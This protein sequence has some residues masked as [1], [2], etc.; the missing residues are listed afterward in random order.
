MIVFFVDDIVKAAE[1]FQIFVMG[2]SSGCSLNVNSDT[3]YVS[4]QIPRLVVPVSLIKKIYGAYLE[5]C[6]P[7]GNSSSSSMTTCLSVEF[8][9]FS[10]IKA[11]LVDKGFSFAEISEHLI[12]VLGPENIRITVVAS[13][14]KESAQLLPRLMSL[15]NLNLI[16][17][18][19]NVTNEVINRKEVNVGEPIPTL[20]LS[21]LNSSNNFK[22]FKPIS[23]NMQRP[24][25]FKTELFDGEILFLVNTANSSYNPM[26]SQSCTS[27]YSAR[28]TGDSHKI[29][30]DLQVQ[31][32]FLQIPSG[33]LFC[34]AEISKCMQLSLIIRGMCG[35]I[36][37]L[38]R[39]MNAS[40]HHSFGD[41]DNFEKP[42][43]VSPL[44]YVEAVVS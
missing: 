7:P 4:I 36:L 19:S 34:G 13:D 12:L 22:L 15:L 43:I 44:W 8:A 3:D 11:A 17:E 6:I 40:L 24:I 42:H 16:K 20:H 9:D 41:K 33:K 5:N 2:I 37:Q 28:F 35:T 38:G 39:R 27:P 25:R 21:V 1:F 14:E 30:F 31:G 26:F 32:K 29:T 10:S 18:A 23:A